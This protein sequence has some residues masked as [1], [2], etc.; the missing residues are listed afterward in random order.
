MPRTT[1]SS[2]MTSSKR[3][4]EVKSTKSQPTTNESAIVHFESDCEPDDESY[5]S[6]TS[7]GELMEIGTE[8]GDQSLH[9]ITIITILD[10]S[11]KRVAC[12]AL[13]DQCCTDKGLIS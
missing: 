7:H 13:L 5:C 1:S 4:G 2:P 10:H 3:R 6:R 9:P 8:N 11:K 12:K